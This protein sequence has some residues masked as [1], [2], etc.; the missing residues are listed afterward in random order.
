MVVSCLIRI[1]PINR[2][3]WLQNL[4]YSSK[5][6]SGHVAL[7]Q[8]RR[9]KDISIKFLGDMVQTQIIIRYIVPKP[10]CSH[11]PF[12]SLLIA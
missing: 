4:K 2:R 12:F 6:A 9:P 3:G 5:V 10:F 8:F 1:S 7:V 11:D